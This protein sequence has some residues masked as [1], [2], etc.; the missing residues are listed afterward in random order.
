MSQKENSLKW[1]EHNLFTKKVPRDAEAAN[2]QVRGPIRDTNLVHSF[3]LQV[4]TTPLISAPLVAFIR[5]SSPVLLEDFCEI[6]KPTRFLALLLGPPATGASLMA[7]GR[8]LGALMTDPFFC[9]NTAY[10][11]STPDNLFSGLSMYMEELTV[12]PPNSWDPATRLD[13]PKAT[14]TLQDRCCCYFLF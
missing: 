13:P 3:F 10:T 14:Q 9:R 7:L 8:T 6:S 12:L 5:L 4:A 1:R 11:A 2:I